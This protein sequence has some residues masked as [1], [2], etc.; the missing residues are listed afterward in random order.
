M[1]QSL[2]LGLKRQRLKDSRF[3]PQQ[4]KALEVEPA[5][6]VVPV[7]VSDPAIVGVVPVGTTTHNTRTGHL[8]SLHGIF[9]I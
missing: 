6:G 8:P 1:S 9:F 2:I 4:A 3:T 5:V 7:T